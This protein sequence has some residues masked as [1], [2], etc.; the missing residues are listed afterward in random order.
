MGPTT[1]QIRLLLQVVGSAAD[2]HVGIDR[3]RQTWSIH[4]TVSGVREAKLLFRLPL[5]IGCKWVDR[6]VAW[7]AVA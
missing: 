2:T 3:I 7:A 1:C 4:P 6:Y 5:R